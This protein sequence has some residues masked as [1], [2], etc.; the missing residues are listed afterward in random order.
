MKPIRIA[1]CTA[2]LLV[3]TLAFAPRAWAED[4]SG[5]S[6]DIKGQIKQK[7]EKILKLMK[8]NEEALLK[9][10]E[11]HQAQPRKV[12]VKVPDTP[13]KTGSK[14]T[15]GGSSTQGNSEG[16]TGTKGEDVAKKLGK[17]VRAQGG[18]IPKELRELAEMIP[19]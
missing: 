13:S 3:L 6:T 14:A 16:A 9:L 5:S 4:G 12:D 2:S 1:L 18:T 11:G 15:P 19:T 10:S 17:L 7:M 8:Q